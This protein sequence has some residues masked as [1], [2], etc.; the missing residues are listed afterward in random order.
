MDS[1]FVKFLFTTRRCDAHEAS[2]N[3]SS[4]ADAAQTSWL[5]AK[6]ITIGHKPEIDSVAKS[7]SS[8]E[9]PFVF[10]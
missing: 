5:D 4:T 6:S 10:V 8:I 1:D 7:D 3:Y 2:R 9:L